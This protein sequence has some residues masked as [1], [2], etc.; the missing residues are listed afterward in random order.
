M[1]Q[2]EQ[3]ASRKK[4]IQRSSNFFDKGKII[5]IYKGGS[6]RETQAVE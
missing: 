1:E 5:S 6:Q 3:F 2:E 4:N